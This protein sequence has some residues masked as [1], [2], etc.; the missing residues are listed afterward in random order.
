MKDS[1]FNDE[2]SY[3]NS[4]YNITKYFDKFFAN[5]IGNLNISPNEVM[6]LSK[7]YYNKGISQKA[8]ANQMFVSEAYVTKMFKSL[9]NKN[10]VKKSIDPKNNTRRQLFLTEKGKKVFEEMIEIF[11][12]FEELLFQKYGKDQI[13]YIAHIMATIGTDSLKFQ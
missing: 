2:S 7:I 3:F 10:L 12:E 6:F 9:N 4:W 13:K 8:I 11:N 5:R 1:V